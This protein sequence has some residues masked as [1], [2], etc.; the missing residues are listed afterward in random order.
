[1]QYRADIDAMRGIAVL[2]VVL[3][4]AFPSLVPSGFLGVDVF[5]V[6]SGY[7]I[8]T[9]ILFDIQSNK[10]SLSHFFAKRIRRLFPALILIL[11]FVLVFGYFVLFSDEYR[12]LG[13]HVA[14]SV[15]FWQNFFLMGE[16]GY[17]DVES[18]YKPLLHLWSLSVEE[19]FYLFWPL[20]ILLLIKF[21]LSL[22][23][24]IIF[25]VLLSLSLNVYFYSSYLEEV[26]FHT[27]TRVWQLGSGALLA[28]YTLKNRDIK[29]RKE[30]SLVGLVVIILVC[31]FAETSQWYW[32]VIVTLS[33][34]VMIAANK[35]YQSFNLLAKVGLISY[36][37]YLWHWVLISFLFIYLGR[38]PE[39]KALLFVIAVAFLFSFLTYRYIE[40]I[41]YVSSSTPYLIIALILLGFVGLF[42]DNNKGLPDRKTIAYEQKQS[43]Q[44][45]RE[46]ATDETCI[47]YAV[48]LLGKKNVFDY[49]RV[50]G[51]NAT[52]IVVI[53]GDSHAHV[54]FPGLANEAKNY[55][56]GV[57]LLANSSCPTLIG[58]QE[59]KN[60][61]SVVQ[62]QIKINQILSII[63]KDKRI[64]KVI[65]ATRG[66]VYIN[67]EVE[68]RFT[69]E[70]V[71]Q[72]LERENKRQFYSLSYQDYFK[73]FRKTV[74]VVLANSHINNMYYLLENPELDFL[75]KE[76]I[77]R[78]YDIFN[79]SLNKNFMGRDLY[80]QRMSIYRKGIESVSRAKLTVLDPIE[81][82]CNEA[83]CFSYK[84]D[85]LYT[86]DDH[87]SVYGS[88]YIIN[89]FKKT[90]FEN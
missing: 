23:K 46:P 40:K 31:L 48:E 69:P 24:V 37:L 60:E 28:V 6:I 18:H 20:L 5:F 77:Q 83:K 75:P 1:M 64:D 85:Y 87:F 22:I 26:Y 61:K 59:G 7:L 3:Y 50:A 16:V 11:S 33:S 4:H 39:I 80:L 56:Y 8:T 63:S 21:D 43:Q 67:G 66:P 19:Q 79:L 17:F 76:T 58:F 47:K 25:F 84:G 52:K 81:A 35:Q 65:M 36:P 57:I 34:L 38:E 89:Y 41:R 44:F 32:A 9:I 51:L 30:F 90:I 71:A 72:S 45:V 70:S 74:D 68:G 86:D 54:L 53:I 88:K 10:F 73:G 13:R 2:L 62:C 12:Q 42:I 49:C 15:I 14:S 55:G 27:F 82:L 78:P 29:V